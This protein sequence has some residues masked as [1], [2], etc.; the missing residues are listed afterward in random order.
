MTELN[1][2]RRIQLLALAAGLPGS[3]IAILLLWLGPYST[4]TAWT[5]TF[6]IAV[7]LVS[8]PDP[9]ANDAVTSTPDVVPGLLSASNSWTAGCCGIAMAVCGS[10]TRATR[11]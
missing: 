1:Y 7:A 4:Q 2:E 3:L 10:R 6:V 11:V 8:E 9:V 5:L